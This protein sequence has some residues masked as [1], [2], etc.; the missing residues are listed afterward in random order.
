MTIKSAA[1]LTLSAS[2]KL[3][4]AAL[5]RAETMGVAI[6]V[7]VVDAGGHLLS[8]ARMDGVGAAAANIVIGKARTAATFRIPTKILAEV[9]LQKPAILS[10]GA[11][12][13]DGGIP[14]MSGEALIGAL[15]IGGLSSEQDHELA[16]LVSLTP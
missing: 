9:A 10:Q 4:R 11:V 2:D 8:F 13:L 12:A 14:L 15:A 7:A 1:H 5:S 16:A 3:I 6:A